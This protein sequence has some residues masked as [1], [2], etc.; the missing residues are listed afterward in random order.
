MNSKI[1]IVEY[2]KKKIDEY[3][4]IL[5]LEGY[6]I[7]LKRKK[8]EEGQKSAVF[9]V[10][11]NYPYRDACIFYYEKSEELFKRDLKA[12]D[13]NILHELIHILTSELSYVA[14]QRYANENQVD[15][16]DEKLV[17]WITEI[18]YF[19]YGKKKEDKKQCK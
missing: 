18:I 6:N 17:D 10:D 4:L 3:S 2:M 19:I 11:V 13:K 14:E 7:T 5:L 1:N 9:E 8:P 12:F 16:A 15:N